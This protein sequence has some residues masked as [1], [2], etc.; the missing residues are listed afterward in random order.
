M[1]SLHSAGFPDS[2]V[3]VAVRLGFAVSESGFRGVESRCYIE[4]VVQGVCPQ[5]RFC[6]KS[7]EKCLF[8]KLGLS[9]LVNFS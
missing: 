6:E 4:F 8:W 1:I 2:D 9:L 3:R 7:H 5:V